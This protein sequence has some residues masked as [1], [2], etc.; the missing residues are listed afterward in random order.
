MRWWIALGALTGHDWRPLESL[1][2]TMSIEVD[3]QDGPGLGPPDVR[4]KGPTD[5]GV[6][7]A[8]VSMGPGTLA[9][10]RVGTQG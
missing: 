10:S 7:Q 3:T 9:P 1:V 4:P 5:K 8:E 2:P 6:R